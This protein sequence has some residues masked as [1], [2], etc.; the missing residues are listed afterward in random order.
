MPKFSSPATK[1]ENSSWNAQVQLQDP[2]LQ[3]APKACLPAF[4]EP[5]L[6]AHRGLQSTLPPTSTPRLGF[7]LMGGGGFGEGERSA[8]FQV[9]SKNPGSGGPLRNRL[10]K[11][12]TAR[13]V[14]KLPRTWSPAQRRALHGT[15]D[16][17]LLPGKRKIPDKGCTQ[18]SP[19][20]TQQT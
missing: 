8:Q 2:E 5:N 18:Q 1:S 14:P 13:G 19:Q 15:W 7:L 20:D 17:R 11:I 16:D 4:T 3:L 6:R 12:E 10:A 9:K